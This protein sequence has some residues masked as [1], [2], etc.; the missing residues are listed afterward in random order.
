MTDAEIVEAYLTASMIPDPD[1]AAAYIRDELGG[2]ANVVL[3]DQINNPTGESWSFI[4]Q[5]G[6]YLYT[7]N[8][9]AQSRAINFLGTVTRDGEDLVVTLD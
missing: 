6:E 8:G 1:A 3:L 7:E 9:I 4:A 2:T 5:G